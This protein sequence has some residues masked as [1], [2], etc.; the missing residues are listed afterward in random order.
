MENQ[1][2]KITHIEENNYL[3][4][5]GKAFDYYFKIIFK[6]YEEDIPVI[7]NNE[8]QILIDGKNGKY[9]FFDCSFSDTTF[10]YDVY[11]PIPINNF[12]YHDYNIPAYIYCIMIGMVSTNI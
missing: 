1:P 4:I 9:Y 8:S 12:N 3:S 11:E 10:I 7:E 2:V 6:I 5:Y